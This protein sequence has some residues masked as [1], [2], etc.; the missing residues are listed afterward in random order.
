MPTPINISASRG[1]AIL[2]LSKWRTPTQVW[3]DIKESRDPGFCAR[4][5]YELAVVEDNAAMRWGRAFEAAIIELAEDKQNIKIGC[6]EK[7]YQEK[8][9]EFLT[10]HIDGLYIYHDLINYILH[11]GKTA[12]YF[13]WH[14]SFGEP[15][16]DR[17]PLDYQVQ[18]Q[19]EM[20]CTFAEK[21]ILSVLVFP[22]RPEEWEEIGWIVKIH[23]DIWEAVDGSG[24]S[25][26]PLSWARTLDE[27][28]YFHQYIIPA[29]AA[30]QQRMIAAY[31]EWWERYIIGDEIPVPQTYDDIRALMREP[32]GTILAD[33]AIESI[34]AEYKQIKSEIGGT[35]PLAK[36]A[37]A[38]KV[39]ALD[40]MRQHGADAVDDDSVDKMILRD[41]AGRKLGTYGKNKNGDLYF[42]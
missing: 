8:E 15:G 5:N 41:S 1:S 31:S 7:F 39:Q 29:D 6:R 21:E 16:T 3:L 9:K 30:L 36:R 28:G 13:S 42:R 35:G 24:I 32:V 20:I 37:E 23:N 18:A 2:G 11:E 27:M 19:H 10:C 40:Y 4:N 14:D 12:S 17:V 34:M 22:R 25:H 33:P 38:I 26:N